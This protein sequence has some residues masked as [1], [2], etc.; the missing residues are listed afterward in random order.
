M[1]QYHKTSSSFGALI[2]E[3]NRFQYGMNRISAVSMARRSEI[4]VAHG[5][6][7]APCAEFIINMN[8]TSNPPFRRSER[9]IGLTFCPVAWNTEIIIMVIEIAGQVMQITRKKC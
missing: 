5:I 8:G 1:T 4:G 6:P 2:F 3:F 7:F 9:I